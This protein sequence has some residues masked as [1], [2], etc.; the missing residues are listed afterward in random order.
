MDIL[1]NF[2]AGSDMGLVR[3]NNEDNLFVPYAPMK[4]RNAAEYYYTG[5]FKNSKSFFCVCDGMGGHNAGEIAS[6]VA[7]NQVHLNYDAILESVT[8]SKSLA[9]VMNNFVSDANINICNYSEQSSELQNMGTTMCGIFFMEN[10][11]YCV[12]VGDSRLYV[13]NGRKVEQLSVDHADSEQTNA[14]TRYLGMPEEFGE[15]IPDVSPFPVKIGGGKRFLLCSDGLCDMLGNDSISTILCECKQPA[16]AVN[17]LIEEAKRMGGRDNITVIV[18]DAKPGNAVVRAAK[19][20]LFIIILAALLA[21]AAI[22]GY[23]YYKSTAP[24]EGDALSALSQSIAT[25]KDLKAVQDSLNQISEANSVEIAAYKSFCSQTADVNGSVSEAKAKL[26]SKIS[27]AE[28]A[29]SAF[30]NELA[31]VISNQ[32]GL[33]EEELLEKEKSYQNWISYSQMTA[34]MEACKT[35]K[36]DLENKIAAY[37]AEQERIKSQN[38]NKS[39]G[40]SKN[41]TGNKS[42]G[43]KPSSGSGNSSSGGSAPAGGGSGSGSGSGSSGGSGSSS[44]SGSSGSS[45]SSSGG[46]RANK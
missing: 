21:G 45:G 25:A 40:G 43:S 38:A 14:L 17:K 6:D 30:K 46:N 41:S 5:A 18:I 29:V 37:N 11:G 10:A 36:G 13:L 15:V 23:T 8:D 4:D 12:N 35:A 24:V 9:P 31:L 20:P 28:G 27:E 19:K 3:T 42:G 1:F 26:N 32:D 22:G 44:N 34:S 33:S 2:A 16:D 39:E 7:A